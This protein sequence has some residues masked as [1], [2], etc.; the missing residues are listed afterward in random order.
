M[1]NSDF[2]GTSAPSGLP[3][4]DYAAL[5][6][7][8]LAHASP[9]DT[10]LDARRR[11]AIGVS[12]LLAPTP[13]FTAGLVGLGWFGHGAM[14]AGWAGVTVLFCAAAPQIVVR[15]G[16]R[17]GAWSDL[18]VPQRRQRL[19]VLPVAMA[20]A[21]AGLILLIALDGPREMATAVLAAVVTSVA[22]FAVTTVWKVSVHTA[23][24]AG[25]AT[26]LTLALGPWWLLC[27]PL[28]VLMGWS[29]VTL[30]EHSPAQV[31]IGAV[32]ASATALTTFAL[33]P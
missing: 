25:T 19:L 33:R 11:A 16:V 18:S 2:A 15:R 9:V 21:T 13:V 20:S 29:R 30:R 14:G 6:V 12:A 8:R 26:V 23:A 28:V 5:P 4:R 27:G 32:L 17:R 3:S 31:I 24:C 22:I 1:K 10:A 7:R